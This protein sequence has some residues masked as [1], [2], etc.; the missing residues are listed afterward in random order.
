MTFAEGVELLPGVAVGG[1]LVLPLVLGERPVFEREFE[2]APGDLRFEVG[3][4][5]GEVFEGLEA[6]AAANRVQSSGNAV[7]RWAWRA[8]ARSGWRLGSCSASWRRVVVSVA[9][10]DRPLG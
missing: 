9:A 3:I 2:E 5:S 10:K 1:G 7:R 6:V 4:G 8:K